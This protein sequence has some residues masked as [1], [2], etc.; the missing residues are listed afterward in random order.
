VIQANIK[1]VTNSL[2]DLFRKPSTQS[3]TMSLMITGGRGAAKLY[4]IWRQAGV[5]RCISKSLDLFLTDERCVPNNR[6]ES[7]FHLVMDTL[8]AGELPQ[9]VFLHRMYD[10]ATDAQNKT[11]S[12]ENLL[13]DSIDILL[14]SMGEDGHI[15]SLFPNSPLLSENKRKVLPVIGL[16]APIQR[17]TITPPVIQS[18]KQVYVLAIGDEKRRKYEEALLDPENISTMPVR[19]VLDRTWIFDLD[20]E[21]DLCP[22]P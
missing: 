21:I 14:L 3:E 19:L 20:E 6:Q 2:L 10:E 7:N 4:D 13:P 18:A 5:F 1:E 15:A 17:L 16:K 12:Y 8:F 22:R 11:H 9:D